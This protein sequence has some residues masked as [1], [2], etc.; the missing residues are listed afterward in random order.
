[1]TISIDLAVHLFYGLGRDSFYPKRPSP[2]YTKFPHYQVAGIPDFLDKNG[3]S[4]DQYAELLHH[5]CLSRFAEEA[6]KGNYLVVVPNTAQKPSQD[7]TYAFRHKIEEGLIDEARKLY[8]E[9]LIVHPDSNEAAGRMARRLQGE[10]RHP[11]FAVEITIY[12]EMNNH[13]VPGNAKRFVSV[14]EQILGIDA[15]LVKGDPHYCGDRLEGKQEFLD[16]HREL[17]FGGQSKLT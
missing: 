9:R 14:F 10:G 13:C 2:Y 4:V 16:A 3:L 7:V 1:M 12:G 6:K 5:L 15:T 17:I 8:L 11:P